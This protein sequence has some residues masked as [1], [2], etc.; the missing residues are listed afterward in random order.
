MDSGDFGTGGGRQPRRSP[1]SGVGSPLTK[2]M[3]WPSAHDKA[4]PHVHGRTLA[5]STGS[6]EAARLDDGPHGRRHLR[7]PD[8][9]HRRADCLPLRLVSAGMH[10]PAMQCKLPQHAAALGARS[11]HTTSNRRRDRANQPPGCERSGEQCVRRGAG[12][13]NPR[14]PP[15]CCMKTGNAPAQAAEREPFGRQILERFVVA[16]YAGHILEPIPGGRAL[17]ADQ[18]AQPP[19]TNDGTAVRLHRLASACLSHLLLELR[20]V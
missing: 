18:S 10:M 1:L 11:A 2:Q 12:V 7:P 16:M 20:S 6:D 13:N 19:L 15:T 17:A 14:G 3:T 5:E 8:L 4:P 9:R